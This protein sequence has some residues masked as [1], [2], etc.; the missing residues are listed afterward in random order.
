MLIHMI[1]GSAET[2]TRLPPDAP[3]ITPA[4]AF[5]FKDII[6]G[7]GVAFLAGLACQFWWLRSRLKQK[8][9][10]GDIGG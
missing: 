6:T 10:I 9:Y 1:T 8:G 2:L 7:L 5:I 4:N 3:L